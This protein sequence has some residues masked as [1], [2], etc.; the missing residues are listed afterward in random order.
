MMKMEN[1]Y[2]VPLA[3]IHYHL[4][5]ATQIDLCDE[6]IDELKNRL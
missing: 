4:T 5:L 2:W 6:R 1:L 3:F